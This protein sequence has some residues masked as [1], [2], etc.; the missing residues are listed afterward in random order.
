MHPDY[1][2]VEANGLELS[3]DNIQSEY[4]IGENTVYNVY[5]TNNHP[6]KVKVTLPA[7]LIHY[8]V[9]I[10]WMGSVVS[11]LKQVEEGN[12]TVTIDPYSDYYLTTLGMPQLRTGRFEIHIE[13]EKL[14]KV[15]YV[16]I[17]DAREYDEI[18]VFEVNSTKLT[19]IKQDNKSYYHIYSHSI[20]HSFNQTY[21]REAFLFKLP[22]TTEKLVFDVAWEKY[23]GLDNFTLPSGYVFD[24]EPRLWI[25]FGYGDGEGV[26][27]KMEDIEINGIYEGHRV[28]EVD[29]VEH[30]VYDMKIG[31][32]YYYLGVN[33][34]S[35]EFTFK[36]IA[37][38]PKE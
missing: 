3:V 35:I 22:Q 21:A 12:K 19:P 7:H 25:D 2:T 23:V 27:L 16:N 4:K 36:I 32:G 31:P 15:I 34:L 10:N 5:L 14:E 8:Q 33:S 17:T 9:P 11:A 30:P 29:M 38:V 28:F 37:L 26:I 13:Y 20:Y 24:L 1:E 6:Y 18:I